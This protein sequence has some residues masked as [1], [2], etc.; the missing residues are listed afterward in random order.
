[1][2]DRDMNLPAVSAKEY[3]ASYDKSS[4]VVIGINRYEAKPLECAVNDADAFA[5]LL[6]GKLGFPSDNVF[7]ILD[8]PPETSDETFPLYSETADR[9]TIERLLLTDLRK[10]VGPDDRV[11][12]FFAGHGLSLSTGPGDQGIGYLVPAGANP[13][14][15]HTLIAMETLTREQSRALA[16]KHVFYI[17]DCCYSGQGAVRGDHSLPRFTK[18]MVSHKA[19]QLLTAGTSVQVVQDNYEGTGHSLFTRTLLQSLGGEAFQPAAGFLSA[20]ML[21]SHMQTSLAA[22]HPDAA[23]QLPQLAALLPDHDAAHGADFVFYVDKVSKVTTVPPLVLDGARRPHQVPWQD[24]EGDQLEVARGLLPGAIRRLAAQVPG[25][26]L[27]GLDVPDLVAGL[28]GRLILPAEAQ[29]PLVSFLA[30]L[31]KTRFGNTDEPTVDALLEQAQTTWLELAELQTRSDEEADQRRAEGGEASDNGFLRRLISDRGFVGDYGEPMSALARIGNS[32]N[33]NDVIVG[34][35]LQP[36]VA[37]L[38]RGED[39]PEDAATNS[40][41]EVAHVVTVTPPGVQPAGYLLTPADERYQPL[42]ALIYLVSSDGEVPIADP[43]ADAEVAFPEAVNVVRDRARAPDGR[44]RTRT[45]RCATGE[46][47]EVLFGADGRP[48]RFWCDAVQLGL[49]QS[50]EPLWLCVLVLSEGG[51]LAVQLDDRLRP[52]RLPPLDNAPEGSDPPSQ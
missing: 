9:E 50:G 5:R 49:A 6:I 52:V 31:D 37:W 30:E 15:P 28:V 47:A 48:V 41:G 11:I 39:S 29:E 16:A 18:E 33:W 4:A 19:R 32:G 3:G 36:L 40:T 45:T 8:P 27:M 14:Q 51:L 34:A 21:H 10:G 44:L 2:T 24:V 46:V 25:V 35:D 22:A 42:L 1:V 26:E 12:V 38:P 17:F 43:G 7:T 20:T 13:D 23:G